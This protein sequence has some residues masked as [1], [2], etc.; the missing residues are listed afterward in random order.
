MCCPRPPGASPSFPKSHPDAQLC[1]LPFFLCHSHAEAP[2]D[3]E[4]L[5]GRCSA[6]PPPH[7]SLPA[8]VWG[9]AL[10]VVLS[11][12]LWTRLSAFSLRMQ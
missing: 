7:P 8:P 2:G 12:G 1:P 4:K 10:M 9:V 6:G 5:S 11:R 3:V